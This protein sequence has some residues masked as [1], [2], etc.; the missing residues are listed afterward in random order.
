M[1]S[2]TSGWPTLRITIFAALRVLPPDLI[3][4]EKASKPF[5]KETGPLASPPPRSVSLDERMVDRLEPAPEP[6]LKSMPSVLARVRMLSIVS[7]TELMK[8]AE[9]CG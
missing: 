4:P 6:N 8:H 7:S 2:S 5:M 1:N 9:H 3:T